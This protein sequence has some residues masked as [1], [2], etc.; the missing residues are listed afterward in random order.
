MRDML[1]LWH[2]VLST[3]EPLSIGHA[4]SNYHGSTCCGHNIGY[5]VAYMRLAAICHKQ[6]RLHCRSHFGKQ[7][8]S[9]S[10][11]PSCQHESSWELQDSQGES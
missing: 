1:S 8:C 4:H 6:H 11:M 2:C 5:S 10:D 7:H 9:N 3:V